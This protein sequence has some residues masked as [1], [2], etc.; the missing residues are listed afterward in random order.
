[1]RAATAAALLSRG[2]SIRNVGTVLASRAQMSSWVIRRAAVGTWATKVAPSS[3]RGSGGDRATIAGARDVGAAVEEVHRAQRRAGARG[4]A[5]R[6]D[7]WRPRQTTAGGDD[8]GGL[9]ARRARCPRRG[10]L[11]A[12]SGPP[13]RR[14]R[15]SRATTS[16]A[17]NSAPWVMRCTAVAVFPAPDGPEIASARPSR[18]TALACKHLQA[19]QRGGDREPLAEQEAPAQRRIR[20][21]RVGDL[22]PVGGDEAL[23]QPGDPHPV[24]RVR[25]AVDGEHRLAVGAGQ[26]ERALHLVRRASRARSRQARPAAP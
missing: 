17:R 6:R 25:M 16:S 18:T 15:S 11:P 14:R 12:P 22:P 19:R 8:P 4:R 9:R 21:R 5:A 23:S 10:R 7:A 26:L 24:P 1:M 13:A 2:T 3:R 20:G